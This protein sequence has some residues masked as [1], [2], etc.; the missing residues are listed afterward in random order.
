VGFIYLQL[1]LPSSIMS[2]GK[3]NIDPY[4]KLEFDLMY[5]NDMSVVTD[6]QLMFAIL[7]QEKVIIVLLWNTLN[8]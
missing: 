6:L 1:F 7:N 4:E 8:F 5:I 3:Y 2:Y